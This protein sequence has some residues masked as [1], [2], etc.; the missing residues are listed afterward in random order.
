MNILTFEQLYQKYDG[1]IPK[2]SLRK[3]LATKGCPVL[4]REKHSPYRIIEDEFD[5]WLRSRKV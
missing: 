4:P 5:K 2:K 3:L 1:Q